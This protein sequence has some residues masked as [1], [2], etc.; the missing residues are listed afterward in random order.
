[1]FGKDEYGVHIHSIQVKLY[2][3][4]QFEIQRSKMSSQSLSF[5]GFLELKMTSFRYFQRTQTTVLT[6]TSKHSL[7]C[8]ERMRD[9]DMLNASWM[10]WS[11]RCE[12]DEYSTIKMRCQTSTATEHSKASEH[13][14]LLI[15]NANR[16]PRR[17]L[18]HHDQG[19]F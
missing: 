13:R 18:H 9:C 11:Y 5:C 1:M 15:H 3:V 2:F 6:T 8:L 10:P 16:T 14:S 4:H 17:D 7:P 19:L 12:E